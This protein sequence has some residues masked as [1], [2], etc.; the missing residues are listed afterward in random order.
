MIS[1][2][3]VQKPPRQI[4]LH[5]T[6]P[7]EFCVSVPCPAV[8]GHSFTFGSQLCG[9]LKDYTPE[10]GRGL[11]AHINQR[12]PHSLKPRRNNPPWLRPGMRATALDGLGIPFGVILPFL[13]DDPHWQKCLVTLLSRIEVVQGPSFLWSHLLES[14]GHCFCLYNPIT[15]LFSDSLT[16]L[17]CSLSSMLSNFLQYG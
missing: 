9:S 16:R 14:M 11:L 5:L 2:K 7:E 12:W 8:T 1:P 17:W 13:K 4:L 15:S 3:Q 10:A 6:A